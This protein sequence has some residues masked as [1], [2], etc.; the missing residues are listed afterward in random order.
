M[1]KLYKIPRALLVSVQCGTLF[2]DVNV[3]S[4]LTDVV[5]A[6]LIWLLSTW[7]IARTTE[8]LN[9]KFHFILINLNLM[10]Y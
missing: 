3:L 7:E 9:F 2:D 4:A 1:K 6:S 8:K 10:K 5:D